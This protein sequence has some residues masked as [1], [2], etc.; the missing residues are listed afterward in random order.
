MIVTRQI[1]KPGLA[2]IELNEK[3]IEKAYRERERFY[4][5]Q[6]AERHFLE[7]FDGEPE[8]VEDISD[9]EQQEFLDS[10]G[11]TVAEAMDPK[12]S[13]YMLNDLVDAYEDARDCNVAENETWRYV[14]T[15]Y[16]EQNQ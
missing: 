13:S 10:Y 11:C 15:K 4:L 9:S 6:D 3:E 16:L 8:D 2:F 1:A 5:L 7:S 14:V 12:S